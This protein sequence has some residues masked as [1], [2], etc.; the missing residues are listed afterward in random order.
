VTLDYGASGNGKFAM[1][2][3]AETW[4]DW[5]DKHGGALLLLARRWTSSHADA[6]DVVQEAFVRFW[7]SRTTVEQPLAYLYACVR[8]CALDWQRGRLRRRVRERVTARPELEPLLTSPL[9]Y[10]ERRQAIEAALR[11]LPE[12]QATVLVMKIWGGLTF[13]Q[14][15]SVLDVSANTAASRYRYA[16]AKLREQLVVESVL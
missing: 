13:P 16:L 4:S 7:R 1:A 12:D 5:L 11:S 14:I 2:E 6:E 10:D 9:E 3:S 15:A 8:T